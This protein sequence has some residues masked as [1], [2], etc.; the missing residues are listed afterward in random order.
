MGH[1]TARQP[2]TRAAGQSFLWACL[3]RSSSKY[4]RAAF[5]RA[6]RHELAGRPRPCLGALLV[7][8]GAIE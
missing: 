4:A 3:H 7:A 6:L 2:V 5:Y 8:S 1:V